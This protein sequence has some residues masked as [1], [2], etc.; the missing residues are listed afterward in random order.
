[1]ITLA[2]FKS[3]SGTVK[4][5]LH[6][7]SLKI[8]CIKEVPIGSRDAR[9]MIKDWL[10]KWEHYCTPAAAGG[11]SFI[12][13]NAAF[14]NSPEGCVSVVTDYAACG[15]LHNLVLSVGAL[16]ESILKHLA[17]QVL[18]SLDYLHNQGLTHNNICCS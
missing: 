2:V 7:S 11:D 15:S 6:A 5:M 9:Q 12:K 10:N 13:V 3:T 16:P 18:R 1:M 4:K 17:K 14:W 8:Y